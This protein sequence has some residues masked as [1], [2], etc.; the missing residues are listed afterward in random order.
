MN[1]RE[2]I[3]ERRSVRSFDKIP[4]DKVTADFIR[5]ELTMINSHEAGVNFR[6]ILNNDSA[7]KKFN[8]SYG[9][10]RNACN[11]VAIVVDSSYVDAEERAG[12][13]A[14]SLALTLTEK[15]I[16]T[17]FV[18]GTFDA[19]NVP[20]P[21]RAGQK[22]LCLLLIGYPDQKNKERILSK[23]IRKVSHKNHSDISDFFISNGEWNIEKSMAVFPYLKDG[24]E[25]IMNAPS[26]MNRRPVRVW[27]ET[28][29]DE[30]QIKIGIPGIKKGQYI[31]LGIAKY[32]FEALAGGVFDVG[33]NATFYKDC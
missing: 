2:A 33:N 14:E 8:T 9:M 23:V 21:L 28:L 22:I 15:G 12:Y 32:N 19:N 16:G 20:V 26:A 10:F 30:P 17:C 31:D 1:K 6:I 18:G 29:D 3:F 4:I 27:I 13:C 5:A 25:G 24:L 7:L 11:Y